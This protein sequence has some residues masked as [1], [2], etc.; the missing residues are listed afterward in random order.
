MVVRRRGADFL[1]DP[2]NWIDNR[3]IAHAPYEA[4]QLENAK[5]LIEKHDITT[6]VDVGA[7]FGLYTVLLG[8]LDRV[9]S[10]VA[11]EPVRRNFAQLMAN[12]FLNHLSAKVDA[13]RLGAWS[14]T[15]T[16]AIHIDPKSTGVSRLDLSTTHRDASAFQTTETIDLVALDSLL[17]MENERVFLKMDIE[18][19]AHHALQGM[20]QFLARNEVFIQVE[21]VGPEEEEGRALLSA[22]GYREIARIENDHIFART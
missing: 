1:L 3:L 16:A 2:Q 15:D 17:Q 6:V 11:F 19:A 4:A 10:V 14:G 9:R 22:L 8:K 20:T 7:N 21:L 13:H 12:I 18:G 5:R